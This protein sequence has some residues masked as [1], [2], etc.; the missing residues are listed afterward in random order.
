MTVTPQKWKTNDKHMRASSFLILGVSSSWL[1]EEEQGRVQP[2]LSS[3]RETVSPWGYRAGDPSTPPYWSLHSRAQNPQSYTEHLEYGVKKN[4]PRAEKGYRPCPPS[5]Q[6]GRTRDPTSQYGNPQ[7]TRASL[8]GLL[9]NMR[10]TWQGMVIFT[11]L[12]VLMV[13]WVYTYAKIY[14]VI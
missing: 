12:I 11:A 6:S 13:L 4:D 5:L 9:G 1:R 10:K 7:F 3:C 14:W 2:V 8:S